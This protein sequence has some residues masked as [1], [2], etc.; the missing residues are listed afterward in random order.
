MTYLITKS[1]HSSILMASDSRAAFHAKN[2]SIQNGSK[3]ILGTIDCIRKTLL[4][5]HSHNGSKIGIQFQGTG[6]FIKNGHYVPITSFKDELT[7]CYL[8]HYPALDKIKNIYNIIQRIV[9]SSDISSKSEGIICCYENKQPLIATFDTSINKLDINYYPYGVHFESAPFPINKMHVMNLNDTISYI[10]EQMDHVKTL[11]P[12]TVGGSI[13]I[14]A[15]KSDGSSEWIQENYRIFN[16]TED[17]L[18]QAIR[19]SDYYYN[20]KYYDPPIEV[21]V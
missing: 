11:H 2:T 14:L 10:N 4:L 5:S 6:T 8:D 16:G 18:M 3:L 12:Y 19:R 20:A 17:E 13:E 15:L 9:I 7:Y 21:K 1:T